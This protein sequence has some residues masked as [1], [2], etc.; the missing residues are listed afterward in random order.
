MADIFCRYCQG[1]LYERIRQNN[2][3]RAFFMLG[4]RTKPPLPARLAHNRVCRAAT[5]IK[6]PHIADEYFNPL[7]RAIVFFSEWGLCRKFDENLMYLGMRDIGGSKSSPPAKPAVRRKK[8]DWFVWLGDVMSIA[9]I[10]LIAARWSGFQ[11]PP[12]PQ[13]ALSFA[14]PK[15][16]YAHRTRVSPRSRGRCGRMSDCRSTPHLF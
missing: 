14:S 1:S 15:S 4:P 10:P 13:P 8:P 7:P 2:R 11:H 6:A 5:R 16:S 9:S 12:V 3:V